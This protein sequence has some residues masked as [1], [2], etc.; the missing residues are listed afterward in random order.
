MANTINFNG[1]GSGIDFSKLT[2]AI[3][4]DSSRPV[5]QL[6]IRSS[7]LSKRS[8]ALKQLNAK[9]A[10]LTE[11][12]KGLK[13]Q[14]LGTGRVAVSSA[15]D[16]VL[17]TTS[18]TATPGTLNLTVT[19]LATS[20]S[21]AS[22][23]YSA[24]G[25]AVLVGGATTATFQLRTGGATTG[26]AITIDS[27]NN[28]LTGLRDAINQANAGISATIVD[29]DGTGT[30]NKLILNS[31]ETGSAG[32][33]ELVETTA[34][35]TGADLGLAALNPPGATTDFLLLDAAFS[36]NGLDLTRAKNAVTDAVT[37]VTL[38]L[39]ATGT[40][41]VTISTDTAEI[42]Q[43]IKSFV[44][45]YNDVQDFIAGQYTKDS[46]GRPGGILAGDPTLRSVQQQLRDALGS[47][48]TTNGGTL[49]SLAEAGLGRD[50]NGR[51]SLD[52]SILSEKLK[53]SAGDVKALLAGKTSAQTGV[54]NQ[55]YDSYN[56]LSDTVTGVV[57]GAINGYQNS[58]KSLDKSINE[59]LARLDLLK[60]SLTRQFAAADAAINQLNGQGTALTTTLNAL[61]KSS[62]N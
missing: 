13:S 29:T 44:T 9:L 53:N 42:G 46:K 37:G 55:I 17:P 23:V 2:D 32:R 31:A 27:S 45:A 43:K 24:A 47:S 41:T 7:D 35:G 36:L 15:V 49:T 11:A 25:A 39:K 51:I 48:S 1:L 26:T 33:V 60:K 50:E 18:A 20:L 6:Q 56:R 3:L 22:R 54:A 62:G 10:T 28:S 16:K 4:T 30:R 5:G 58:I 21:Q 8:D 38:N 52:N 40:A 34:T 61:T 19:R 59:Q 57:Q 14:D 12:A